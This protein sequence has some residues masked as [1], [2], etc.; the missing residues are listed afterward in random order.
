MGSTF[1]ALHS[2]NIVLIYMTRSFVFPFNS[3]SF[4]HL[5]R[6]WLIGPQDLYYNPH[7]SMKRKGVTNIYVT[8]KTLA[9]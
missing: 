9:M 2:G 1:Q 3:Y 6:L 7:P 8:F 4:Q 5:G